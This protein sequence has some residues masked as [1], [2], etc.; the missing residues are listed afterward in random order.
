MCVCITFS[1]T[2]FKSQISQNAICILATAST[3]YIND[4]F[5]LFSNLGLIQF[6]DDASESL[7]SNIKKT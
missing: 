5:S 4:S 7:S 1:K 2:F 6:T 3:L